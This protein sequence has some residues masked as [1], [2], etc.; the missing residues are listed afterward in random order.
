MA[1][2]Q[3][4]LY[5]GSVS[6]LRSEVAKRRAAHAGVWPPIS[7]SL[8]QSLCADYSTVAAELCRPAVVHL[9]SRRIGTGTGPYNA[10]SWTEGGQDRDGG[11][12]A[13]QQ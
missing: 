10:H 6:E 4:Q 8:A 7:L 1:P 13:P 3:A 5:E 2:V 9:P 12:M 11:Q